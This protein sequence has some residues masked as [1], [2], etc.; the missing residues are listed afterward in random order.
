MRLLNKTIVNSKEAIKKIKETNLPIRQSC[1]ISKTCKSLEEQVNF[2][3][4]QRVELIKKYGV[5]KE[6][7]YT[8]EASDQ[9]AVEKYVSEYNELL[10][11]EEEIDVRTL[12]IDDLESIYLTPQEFSTVE[13]I[14]E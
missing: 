1:A 9:E 8:I 14:I 4:E 5:E 11:L 3:E 10:N 13:F 12:S 6:G 2:I 7:G